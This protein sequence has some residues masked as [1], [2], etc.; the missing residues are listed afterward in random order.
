MIQFYPPLT[1]PQAVAMECDGGYRWLTDTGNSVLQMPQSWVSSHS[2]LQSPQNL[3]ACYQQGV[4]HS[5]CSSAPSH[6]YF[7]STLLVALF[8]SSSH[9]AGW[10]PVWEAWGTSTGIW[11][12][13]GDLLWGFCH[14]GILHEVPCASEESPFGTEISHT[15][16]TAKLAWATGC[17]CV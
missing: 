15:P 7:F 1:V 12:L 2:Q 16:H 9:L 13:C 5:T 3:L 14:P 11:F 8:S 4:Q 17:A 10:G 6:L